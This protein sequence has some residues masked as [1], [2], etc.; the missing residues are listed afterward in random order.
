MPT[1]NN[2]EPEGDLGKVKILHYNCWV[3]YM[4]PRLSAPS[5]GKARRELVL[6]V[7]RAQSKMRQCL[8]NQRDDKK[9]KH[10]VKGIYF[11][12]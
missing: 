11:K 7:P 10:C 3:D 1:R 5:F 6:S 4:A 2:F 9:M 12:E 8:S